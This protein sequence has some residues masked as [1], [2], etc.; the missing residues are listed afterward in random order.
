MDNASI[1][2]SNLYTLDNKPTIA[3]IGSYIDT[4]HWLA[5]CDFIEKKYLAVPKV[6]Y[7]KC[8]MARGWNVKYKKGGKAI[9]TLYPNKHYFTCLIVIADKNQPDAEFILPTCEE[10]V[11]TIYS[12]TKSVMGGKWLVL[13][14]TNDKILNNV[15]EL[16][17]LRMK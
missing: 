5:L 12:K 1:N 17:Y 15:K 8:S 16:I 2:W 9:C 11:Q 13:D 14:I 4:P 10:Y 3:E 7:S 6:E